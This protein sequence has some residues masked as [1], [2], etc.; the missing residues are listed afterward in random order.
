MNWSWRLLAAAST[1]CFLGSVFHNNA[2]DICDELV[3]VFCTMKSLGFIILEA[4]VAFANRLPGHEI[5]L[6]PKRN[7]SLGSGGEAGEGAGNFVSE[8][9]RSIFKRSKR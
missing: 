1:Q 4:L 5:G 8:C 2:N 3:E 9:D 7:R 6:L